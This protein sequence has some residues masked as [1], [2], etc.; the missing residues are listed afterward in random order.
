MADSSGET[1][2]SEGVLCALMDH[3]ASPG[4]QTKFESFFREHCGGFAAVDSAGGTGDLGEL[5]HE[6]TAVYE[7]FTAM[8]EESLAEFLD[9]HNITGAQL[10]KHCKDVGDY[11]AGAAAG[12]KQCCA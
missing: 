6:Y 2:V 5:K 9:R 10:Y 7:R 1:D 8:F 3:I 11:S 4:F 12:A